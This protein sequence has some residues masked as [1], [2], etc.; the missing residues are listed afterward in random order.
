M[1]AYPIPGGNEAYR[2]RPQKIMRH[3]VLEAY[4]GDLLNGVPG[5]DMYGARVLASSYPG[6]VIMMPPSLS[7]RRLL[8][9]IIEH[10][11]RVGLVVANQ[12]IFDE[13]WET[14]KQFPDHEMDA[15]HFGSA[16]NAVAPNEDFAKIADEMNNKNAFIEFCHKMGVATPGTIL[17]NSI[18]EFDATSIELPGSGYPVYV[19]AAVSA[20]G[21]HVICCKN[22]E[23]LVAAVNKMPGAFQVQE[24][25]SPK[26][27][28][29]NIQYTEV[30]G[31]RHHGPLTLQKLDGNEHNG[32]VYPSG[33]DVDIVQPL[34]DKLAEAMTE[35]GMKSTW[36]FDVAVT[37]GRGALFIEANPRWN[38]AS[39]Y[40]H[41]AERLNAQA[42]EGQYVKP[43]H[44]NFDFMFREYADWEYN[45]SHG[46]GIILI[47]WG[48]IA[49]HKLGLL[50][51]GTPE[52]RE[53]LL[54]TFRSKYC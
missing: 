14:A 30:G 15:F 38:G 27:G 36:A 31:V 16:A 52:Q 41:P 54:N 34:A 51:I 9:K 17:F 46:S 23:E 44:T 5:V 21:M 7:D 22:D 35:R 53:S 33:I 49:A 50:V 45:P 11:K 42:W 8:D 47:N 19:K 4:P 13:I 37:P 1:S 6:D 20:S 2:G 18:E 25:L 3:N 10:Y 24:G 43:R 32:N 26:T 40:S 39:Y 12:F 29:Y 48:T 28:F